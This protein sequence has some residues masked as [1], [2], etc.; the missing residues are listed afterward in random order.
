MLNKLLSAKVCLVKIIIICFNIMYLILLPYDYIYEKFIANSPLKIL[1]NIID[2][3][4]TELHLLAHGVFVFYTYIYC[5]I[6]IVFCFLA[7]K[8]RFKTFLIWLILGSFNLYMLIYIILH[9]T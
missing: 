6:F 2:I 4:F 7:K 8:I 1:Y 3:I 5:I 9:A